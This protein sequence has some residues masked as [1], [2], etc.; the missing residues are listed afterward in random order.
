MSTTMVTWS[1]FSLW[2]EA[3]APYCLALAGSRMK[4]LVR[5]VNLNKHAKMVKNAAGG[6]GLANAEPSVHRPHKFPR[7]YSPLLGRAAGRPA[8]KRGFGQI[9]RSSLLQQRPE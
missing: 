7:Q 8:A 9:R 6:C 4:E 1:A 5:L 3:N 2:T